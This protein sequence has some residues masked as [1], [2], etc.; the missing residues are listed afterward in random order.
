MALSPP[1]LVKLTLA[2]EKQRRSRGVPIADGGQSNQART[3]KDNIASVREVATY[4]KCGK[5]PPRN[6]MSGLLS[7]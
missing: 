7:E 4:Y 2:G 3:E 5:S 6:N 1:R